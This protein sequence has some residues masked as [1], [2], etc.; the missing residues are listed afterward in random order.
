MT[1]IQ[2]IHVECTNRCN[3]N[4]A[5]CYADATLQHSIELPVASAYEAIRELKSV[6]LESVS[7]SGGEPLLYKN[8]F[9]LINHCKHEGLSV[10]LNTNGTA[11]NEKLL[12]RLISSKPDLTVVSLHGSNPVTHG[13]LT[14]KEGSF[15]DVV[16]T[17]QDLLEANLA[18][19]TSVTINK[20]NLGDLEDLVALNAALGIEM[21]FVFRFLSVGRGHASSVKY[22][23]TPRE[24][25]EA[26]SKLVN[27]AK[28]IGL[29][30]KHTAESPYHSWESDDVLPHSC[31]AGIRYCVLA[32]NGDVYACTGLRDPTLLCGNINNSR[33]LDIWEHSSVMK[34]LRQAITHPQSS[35]EGNCRTCAHLVAC[36]GGCRASAYAGGRNIYASDPTCWHQ[37]NSENIKQEQ[38]N[39]K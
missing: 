30:L 1:K 21:M 37:F 15:Y 32:A 22:H 26:C 29:N 5:H 7:L 23:V 12:S 33:I 35:L 19:A 11:R 27:T 10:T 28:S 14:R 6:G 2:S 18:V 4:C 38:Y 36:K 31:E 20:Q 8:I 3:L 9:N 24:H 16:R 34:R 39:V 13:L 17:I 25:A